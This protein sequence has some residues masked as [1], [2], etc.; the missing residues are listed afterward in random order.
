MVDAHAIVRSLSAK[1]ETMIRKIGDNSSS[2][3]QHT[4]GRFNDFAGKFSSYF[5][6]MFI[7]HNIGTFWMCMEIQITQLVEHY[8]GKVHLPI[9]NS[10]RECNKLQKYYQNFV[11]RFEDARFTVTVPKKR[12]KTEEATLMAK[13]K[14]RRNKL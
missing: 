7:A 14:H 2:M 13:K 8:I 6:Q 11:D 3:L 4:A 12:K 10:E 5:V 1:I 9:L